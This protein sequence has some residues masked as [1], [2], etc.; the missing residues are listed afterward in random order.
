MRSSFEKILKIEREKKK[1]KPCP[2]I[3]LGLQN[4]QKEIGLAEDIAKCKTTFSS[5]RPCFHCCKAKKMASVIWAKI[6]KKYNL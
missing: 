2:F 5:R 3:G 4:R 1:E 6:R